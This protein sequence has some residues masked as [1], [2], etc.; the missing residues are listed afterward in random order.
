MLAGLHEV[1]LYAAWCHGVMNGSPL[2]AAAW[3]G[4]GLIWRPEVG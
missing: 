3:L 1:C 4:A 2:R